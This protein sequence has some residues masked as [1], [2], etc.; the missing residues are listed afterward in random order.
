[1][2][3][4]IREV[5]NLLDLPGKACFALTGGG[6]K[7]TLLGI[8][9]HAFRSLDIPVIMT[10]TTKVQRPFPVDV[11]WFVESPDPKERMRRVRAKLRPGAL[12]MVVSRPYGD[13]KW[14][15]VSSK[16]V[17]ELF[18]SVA[19]GVLLNEADGALHRPIKA[20]ANHEP[21]IAASTTHVIPIVGLTALGVPLDEDHAFRPRLIAEITGLALGERI[22][23]SAVVRLMTDP[24]GL[25]KG[26][27]DTAEIIPILNQADT[28]SLKTAGK[29]IAR[30]ILNIRDRIES[31]Y[32]AKFEPVPSFCLFLREKG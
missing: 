27:P 25:A 13:H 16:W 12:G 11:D 15:G 29:R 1:M 22:T 3:L 23:E 32:V 4:T 26:A 14:K 9:G 28:P 21:V 19:K 17:D 7:T 2:S 18:T 10:T 30:E 8:L 24:R 20:P 6:G 31:V 5:I